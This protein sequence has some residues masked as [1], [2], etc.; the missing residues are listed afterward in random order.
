MKGNIDATSESISHRCSSPGAPTPVYLQVS[1]SGTFTASLALQRT[2]TAP[3]LA[4][5]LVAGQK[6]YRLIATAYTS[7]TAVSELISTL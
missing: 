5:Y 6:E 1:I 3:V 7:G 4:D 2:Y